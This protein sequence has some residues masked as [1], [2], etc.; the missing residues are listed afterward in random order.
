MGKKSSLETGIQNTIKRHLIKWVFFFEVSFNMTRIWFR[1]DTQLFSMVFY[2]S[3]SSPFTCYPR[4][5]LC[6]YLTGFKK[7]ITFYHR[8]ILK[9]ISSYWPHNHWKLRQI[10]MYRMY[11][12]T[13]FRSGPLVISEECGKQRK[14]E[15]TVKIEICIA[16]VSTVVTSN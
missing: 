15:R 4:L 16:L 13:A 7:L 14:S 11:T 1:L 6:P 2:C 9:F 8:H 5:F 3:L 12:K 10:N